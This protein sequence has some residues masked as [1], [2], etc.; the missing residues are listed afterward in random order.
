MYRCL[1]SPQA[2]CLRG[3]KDLH[4]REYLTTLTTRRGQAIPMVDTDRLGRLLAEGCTLVVDSLNHLD[5]IL[6]VT[7]RA[8]QWWSGELVQVNAYLTTGNTQGFDCTS[9]T[10]A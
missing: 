2:R 3:G 7:C 10:M 1:T 8:L 5:P 4:P 9:T 6:D